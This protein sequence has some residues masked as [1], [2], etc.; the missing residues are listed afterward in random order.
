MTFK[1]IWST[2]AG[3]F[4]WLTITECVDMDDALDHWITHVVGTDVPR[5]AVIDKISRV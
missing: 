1:F 5:D 2:P 3:R 4:G